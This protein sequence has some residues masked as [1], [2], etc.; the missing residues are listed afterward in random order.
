MRAALL[1]FFTLC[2]A[3]PPFAGPT[4]IGPLVCSDPTCPT[5]FPGGPT[6]NNSN[7]HLRDISVALAGDGFFYL[8]GTST[9]SGDSYWSD[10]YGV[11]RMWRSATLT[12]GSF[13]PG[14]RVVF[15]VTRDCPTCGNCTLP[16]TPETCP[17]GE[18][19]RVWAPEYHFLPS[20]LAALP[21][22]NGSFIALHLHCAGGFSGVLAS[23]T[24][25]PFGPYEA[26]NKGIHGGDVTLF[27]HANGTVYAGSSGPL[28]LSRLSANL[29]AVEE[30][31]TLSPTCDGDCSHEYVGFEG[32]Q[33]LARG[34]AFFLCAS[35]YGNATAHGGP[36]WPAIGNETA[37]SNI[38][39]ST[40]C[41]SAATLR[42]PFLDPSGDP[43][44]WLSVPKG[45]HN[46]FFEDGAG[47]LFSTLWYGS[48]SRDMPPS[49]KPLVDLPSLVSVEVVGGRLVAVGDPAA[50]PQSY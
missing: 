39:Y 33:F 2:V 47:N 43:G 17:S 15:N 26:I 36:R 27:E 41:A 4:L 24:G 37:A 6:V 8:T 19:A 16:N 50:A 13:E 7:F 25:H 14:G 31:I 22:A 38:Y 10:V 11:V 3:I 42:G 18:C 30:V 44:G 35:A 21:A 34:G 40:Y 12:P 49:D 1:S 5:P 28:A 48:S 46:T 29:S 32:M 45:G 23:T 9:S 20:T